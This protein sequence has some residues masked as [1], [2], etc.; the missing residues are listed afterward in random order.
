MG[1]VMLTGKSIVQE[2]STGEDDADKEE[3]GN[4]HEHIDVVCREISHRSPISKK[5]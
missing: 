1:A 2:C 3:S 5:V 4:G